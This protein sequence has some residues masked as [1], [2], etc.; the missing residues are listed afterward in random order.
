MSALLGG[1]FW[2]MSPSVSP[3]VDGGWRIYFC[4]LGAKNVFFVFRSG[5]SLSFCSCRFS[6]NGTMF[7]KKEGGGVIR[8]PPIVFAQIVKIQPITDP[9]KQTTTTQFFD[10]CCFLME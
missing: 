2:N 10:R 6:E 3:N 9:I 5:R 8:V 1:V 4:L 7:P